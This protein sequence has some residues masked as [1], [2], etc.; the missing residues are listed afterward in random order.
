ME[1]HRSLKSTT[2]PLVLCALLAS[3]LLTACGGSIEHEPLVD[4]EGKPIPVPDPYDRWL[5]VQNTTP[6]AGPV[7]LRPTLEISF[8]D[9]INPQ[10]FLTYGV[11][12]L[13]SGGILISGDAQYIMTRKAIRWT[14]RRNLEPDFRYNLTLSGTSLRSVT[15]APLLPLNR[16]TVFVADGSLPIT[17]EPALPPATWAE[18][19]A[20][21]TNRCASC[22]RD[23]DWQ[24][25]P[26]TQKSLTTQPSQQ[27]EFPLVRAFDPSSSYLMHK[28]LPDYPVRRFT[29]QPPPWT[30]NNA[31][32]S[33]QELAKIESWILL[34]AKP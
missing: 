28:I 10:T 19:D 20:I 6:P 33:P 31:P 26:L 29:V 17:T 14:P 32:L 16:P 15:N 22:H 8:Y 27:S 34:G 3:C 25:N 1:N 30:D 18:V 11:V 12:S 13:Q 5:M 2:W 21:F 24:L 7:S 9:Y 4:Q 23:P